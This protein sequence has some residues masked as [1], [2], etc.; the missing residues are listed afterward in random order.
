MKIAYVAGPYKAPT[1]YQQRRNT[2]AAELVAVELLLMG[3]ATFIPPRNYGGLDGVVPELEFLERDLEHLHRA[4]LLV[5]LPGWESSQGT[6]AEIHQAHYELTPVYFWPDD[7]EQIQLALRDP[8]PFTDFG[9]GE[10]DIA[11]EPDPRLREAL[12]SYSPDD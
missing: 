3:Y 6:L 12:A 11:F 8:D 7:R 9:A 5:V 4:D 1:V 10:V 2:D